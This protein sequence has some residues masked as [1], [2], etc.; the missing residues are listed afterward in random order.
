MVTSQALGNISSVEIKQYYALWSLSN[1]LLD[2][3]LTVKQGCVSA[4]ELIYTQLARE[5]LLSS[6]NPF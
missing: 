1:S 3:W 2:N 6:L 5:K 4:K